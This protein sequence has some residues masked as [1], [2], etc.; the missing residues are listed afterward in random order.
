[1]AGSSL[2]CGQHCS[3]V[4]EGGSW[5]ATN[6]FSEQAVRRAY[7]F[8]GTLSGTW[9]QREACLD[10]QA[11]EPVARGVQPLVLNELGIQYN[12]A[13][14][15]QQ[16]TH[17]LALLASPNACPATQAVLKTDVFQRMS[18]RV[19][20]RPQ[21]SSLLRLL[22]QDGVAKFTPALAAEHEAILQDGRALESLRAIITKAL[23]AAPSRHGIT[24]L[25][26]ARGG[27]GW[28]SN[29]HRLHVER[30][31][32]PLLVHTLPVL[33]GIADGYLGD[34]ATFGGVVLLR[35]AGR[36]LSKREYG[37]GIW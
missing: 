23:D 7:E 37:S 20:R 32:K 21:N 11:V 35:L 22:E 13:A 31:L 5:T 28:A 12:A 3:A 30:A 27:S 36:N 16:R 2:R 15:H 8:A 29:D 10:K 4:A 33:Q 25:S 9:R 19:E 18:P 34:A 17:L 26:V 24:T 14:V 6:P 1:M